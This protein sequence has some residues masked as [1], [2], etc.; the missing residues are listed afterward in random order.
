VTFFKATIGNNRGTPTKFRCPQHYCHACDV[1]KTSGGSMMMKCNRCESAYH[2]TCLDKTKTQR[3]SKQNIVCEKHCPEG[4]VYKWRYNMNQTGDEVGEIVEESANPPKRPKIYKNQ[5]DLYDPCEVNFQDKDEDK[6][7]GHK[8]ALCSKPFNEK[9]IEG[10][11]L[12]PFFLSASSAARK[13]RVHEE[14]ANFCPEVFVDEKGRYCNVIAAV[15][16]GRRTSCGACGRS[17]A[18]I[19]CV[20]GKCKF[21]YHVGCAFDSGWKFA[22]GDSTFI[23]PTH[24]LD[25]QQTD[26]WGHC[27]TPVD[28]GGFWMQCESCE[29]WFHP[30]CV[31][32]KNEVAK[33]FQ[34]YRCPCCREKYGIVP[35][36]L[37]D[38]D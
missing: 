14:C 8:C 13:I 27:L 29:N 35:L 34:T 2:M 38:V 30:K 33:S 15:K 17:G 12:P 6:E 23:C 21:S 1:V 32:M 22:A 36:T 25:D 37:E 3:I 5:V 9:G 19:G 24:R 18:T 31:S 20:V 28:N 26:T 11:M 10:K 7:Q 16:R 4:Q